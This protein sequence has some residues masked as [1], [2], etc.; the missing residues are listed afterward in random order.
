[1]QNLALKLLASSLPDCLKHSKA[2]N[3]QVK[4]YRGFDRWKSWASQFTEVNVFPA[5]IIYIALFVFQLIQYVSCH[6][7]DGLYYG[8]KWVHGISGYENPL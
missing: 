1:M 6:I 5:C 8:I 3:T 7:I 4:Y 2:K